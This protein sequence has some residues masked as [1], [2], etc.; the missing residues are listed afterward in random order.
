M[1][2]KLDLSIGVAVGSSTQIALFVVPF[3]TLLGWW[4]DEPMTLNFSEFEMI[5]LVM[6]VLI[7][8][9]LVKDGESNWLLGGMLVASYGILATAF[10]FHPTEPGEGVVASLGTQLRTGSAGSGGEAG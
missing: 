4:L 1:S 5:V 3:V 6:S 7:V 10:W 8:N 9:F 2:D